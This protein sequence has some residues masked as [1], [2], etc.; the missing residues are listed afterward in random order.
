VPV[1]TVAVTGGS[2]LIGSATLADLHDHGYRTVNVDRRRPDERIADGYRRTDLLDA[3]EVYGSLAACDADAV[4]H[5]GTIPNP[6]EDPEHVTYESNVQSAYHVLEAA[7]ALD[8][9]SVCLASSINAIGRTFQDAPPE[10]AYLPVDEDHPATPRDPYGV[11]KRAMEV[12]AAGFGRREDAP[13]TISTLRFP[14]VRSAEYV[15]AMSAE[16]RSLDA[17]RDRHAPGDNPLFDYLHVADAASAACRAVEADFAGHETFWVCAAD[18]SVAPL[19]ATLV[20]TFYPDIET[21]FEPSGHEGLLS[22]DKAREYLGWE[23][24]HSWRD[25]GGT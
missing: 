19:T 8:L 21:R 17:L 20:G 9:E 22:I 24:A 1:D 15:A 5:L 3:G 23:P 12:T 25:E 2:G 6:L 13:R 16:D 11:A 14:G 18:T 7:T 10:V 4:V